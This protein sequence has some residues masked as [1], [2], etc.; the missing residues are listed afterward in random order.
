MNNTNKYT[1][2][3]WLA[4]VTVALLGCIQSQVIK[5]SSSIQSPED[6]LMCAQRRLLAEGYTPAGGDLALGYVRLER[7]LDSAA[8]L[9]LSGKQFTDVI[10]VTA[11]PGAGGTSVQVRAETLSSD[12]LRTGS[13]TQPT[14][15]TSVSDG[16]Q[17]DADLVISACGSRQ[18][19]DHR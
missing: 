9:L 3:V 7:R 2:A 19:H 12:M 13:M 15:G 17:R 16:V 10:T 4:V 8:A 18:P 5:T 6:A 1:T 11:T 14:G